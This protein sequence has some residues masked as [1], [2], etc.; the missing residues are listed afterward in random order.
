MDSYLT[1]M[2]TGKKQHVTDMTN[3]SRTML[4]NIFEKKWDEEL[5]RMMDI[6]ENLL[7]Q[8]VDSSCVVGMLDKSILGREIPVA[9]LAGDQH[10]AL[11]GQGC[12]TP[13][14]CKNTYGTGCFVLMNTG[15]T[16][17]RSPAGC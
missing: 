3:A 9:A 17:V 16:P 11:F 14:L 8:V 4:F 13:G 5:L 12:F 2:L 6:P 10:A 1:F 7:P 15:K